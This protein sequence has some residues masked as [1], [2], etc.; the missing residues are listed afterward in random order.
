[1]GGARRRLG[2]DVPHHFSAFH[3]PW[4]LDTPPT[5]PDLRRARRIA[6][7]AGL[8]YVLSRQRPRCRLATP[9][10]RPVRGADRARLGTRSSAIRWRRASAR[11]ATPPSPAV[12]DD[13]VDISAAVASSDDRRLRDQ[14]RSEHQHRRPEE[15][16][17]AQIVGTAF[18]H[19]RADGVGW[20]SAA[21]PPPP[22]RGR[23]AGIVADGCDRGYLALLPQ[24]VVK[25][26][27]KQI[28]AAD[29]ARRLPPSGRAAPRIADGGRRGSP[30]RAARVT[31]RRNAEPR[32]SQAS[33]K[34][35]ISRSRG[36]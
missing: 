10:A 1:M 2:R 25:P 36:G 12:F 35:C 20:R 28:T 27:Y 5:P 22:R 15:S 31:A 26:E 8:L 9:S 32:H 34:A 17:G 7:K 30:R 14:P 11:A 21:A 29:D 23:R 4:M 13:A 16:A 24:R 18:A 33:A 6:E 3:P 19:R